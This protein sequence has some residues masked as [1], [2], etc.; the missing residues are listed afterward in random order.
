MP[1]RLLPHRTAAELY[2]RNLEIPWIVMEES[3]RIVTR[4]R[5]GGEPA[6]RAFTERFKERAPADPL[7]LGPRELRRALDALPRDDRTRL[8]RVARR[9]TA[10][11]SAQRKALRDVEV[12][13]PGGRA[14]H[15]VTPVDRA[16]CYA[17]GGRHPLPSSALMTAIPARVAGVREIWIA[18]PKPAPMT[19]AAAALAE[20]E[21]VLVAGGAHAIAA[22]A[23]GAGPVPAC[24]AVVG[25]G[26]LYVTAAKQFVA[27]RVA[28][29]MLAGPSELVVLAD[30][31]ADPALVAADL[32]AQAE[33]DVEAMPVLVTTHR[34]LLDQV[35]QE[36][37]RQLADL[38][39]APTARTALANGGAIWCRTLDAAC[40]VCS[41]LAA[42]HL[43]LLVAD[44]ESVRS[45][46]SQ[47]GALFLGAGAAEVFGDY[48]AGP[49]HTLPTSRT[50]RSYA[51]LSVFTFLRARTWMR[52]DD[53]GAA[54]VLAED[55]AWFGRVEGLE[56]HARAAERR[57]VSPR[58]ARPKRRRS[59]R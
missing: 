23:F 14:G 33:H 2:Q 3:R 36:L 25:P 13:I 20:A 51:G 18:T 56:A 34:P 19:L 11:A 15:A 41:E 22:L 24:D 17:P 29:D 52:I 27:G 4:V 6:L 47:Y 40:E 8:E 35:E 5:E 31:T 53:P 12:A 21:G 1:D 57:L 46:V 9:I 45:R 37:Q 26:N 42:E 58:L 39:T 16:G 10:F 50:A 7:V 30:R 54:R 28:I 48:G 38:P 49:N 55:A 32:L 44:P 43:E 59:T